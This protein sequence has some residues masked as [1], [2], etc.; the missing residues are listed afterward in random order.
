MVARTESAQLTVASLLGFGTD[1]GGVGI[2]HPT[3][4]L[5]EGHVGRLAVSLPHCPLGSVFQY[6]IQVPWGQVQQSLFSRTT[7]D[8][9]KEFIQ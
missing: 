5:N 2:G 6:W 4:L 9:A 3:Q 1:S 7:G 8:I